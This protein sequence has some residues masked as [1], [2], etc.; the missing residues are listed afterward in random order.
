MDDI[1]L[2][3]DFVA[4][5]KIVHAVLDRMDHQWLNDLP[6]FDAINPSAENMA[7]HIYDQVVEGMKDT[8]GRAGSLGA[9]LGNRPVQRDIQAVRSFQP[10]AFS[11]GLRLTGEASWS[12]YIFG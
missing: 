6:P 10:S 5:K 3:V 1:G 8:A 2:L 4:L 7:K 9:P 11:F 12:F